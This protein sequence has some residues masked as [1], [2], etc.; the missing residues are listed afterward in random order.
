MTCEGF[1]ALWHIACQE[2]QKARQLQVAFAA[3]SDADAA[4]KHASRTKKMLA[5]KTRR[6]KAMHVIHYLVNLEILV[7]E[8]RCSKLPLRRTIG[9]VKI[10]FARYYRIPRRSTGA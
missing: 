5:T 9:F 4:R 1:D 2:Q 10:L 8:L 7:G 3:S 6:H